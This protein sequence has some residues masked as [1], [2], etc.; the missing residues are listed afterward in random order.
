[1][2][3]W[4]KVK[5]SISMGDYS[6]QKEERNCFKD[7]N[8]SELRFEHAI[9]EQI[10]KVSATQVLR[11]IWQFNL[12]MLLSSRTIE[13]IM[14]FCSAQRERMSADLKGT[15]AY[16]ALQQCDVTSKHI[17]STRLKLWWILQQ[18]SRAKKKVV[19]FGNQA[20]WFLFVRQATLWHSER[21]STAIFCQIPSGSVVAAGSWFVSFPLLLAPL[22]GLTV[23]NSV[24]HLQSLHFAHIGLVQMNA[25][26][27]TS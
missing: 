16:A 22:F 6:T 4:R 8:Q 13:I 1:M 20:R 19:C 7:V 3:Q 14:F 10:V 5:D 12:Q 21:K 11:C 9:R 27:D 26:L 25:N 18:A 17:L 2:T 23:I 15:S 24:V